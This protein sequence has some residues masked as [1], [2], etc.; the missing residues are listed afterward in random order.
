MRNFSK[1]E[2]NRLEDDGFQIVGKPKPKARDQKAYHDKQ[3]GKK[4]HHH[5]KPTEHHGKPAH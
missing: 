4:H 1:N 3:H 2:Q 5:G